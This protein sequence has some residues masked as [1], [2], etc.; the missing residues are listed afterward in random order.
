[1]ANTPQQNAESNARNIAKAQA[2]RARQ[3]GGELTAID[4]SNNAKRRSQGKMVIDFNG[5]SRES[6][7]PIAT[8]DIQTKTAPLP[9]MEMDST[10]ANQGILQS[11]QVAA[12]FQPAEG[13]FEAQTADVNDNVLSILQKQIEDLSDAENN[14]VTAED[15]FRQAQRESGIL[16]KQERSNQLQ[17]QLNEV[18]SRGQANQLAVVGQGRGIPE[19]ILGGQQ[20]QFARET[21][22]E[23][24]P[25]SAQLSAAQGDLEMA[26]RNVETLFK[27]KT[28][29]AKADYDFNVKV[30]NMVSEFATG[31]ENAKLEDIKMKE[32]RKYKETERGYTEA[33]NASQ[34]AFSNGQSELGGKINQ[35]DYKSPT[36]KADLAKLQGQLKDP[37]RELQ[38]EKLK[39]DLAPNPD[40][41]SVVKIDGTDYI[42][43][44][45]GTISLP[46]LPNM[47]GNVA[48]TEKTK[49]TIEKLDLLTRTEKGEVP[50]ALRASAG[51]IRS[52]RIPPGFIN[53]VND[54][55]SEVKTIMSGLVLD[56]LGRVKA[57]GISFG[58]LSN[59]ERQAVGDAA[60]VLVSSSIYEGEGDD[61]VPTGRFKISE[62]KVQEAFDTISKYKKIDFERRTNMSW[63]EYTN[64]PGLYAQNELAKSEDILSTHYANP[65]YS[66]LIEQA[67]ADYPEYDSA[68]ILQI[69]G[70]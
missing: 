34:M 51:A 20:A 19:A 40:I 44:K 49:D 35:L 1:M 37:L 50:L 43:Y 23:S 42:R 64:N 69:L 31:Q 57:D 10:L 60:T 58:N 29:D 27:I 12:K 24:L 39:Q 17:G 28:A 7:T 45:D 15:S 26:Q 59:G 46:I 62:G 54:W 8:T 4:K 52:K 67:V 18:V 22:I 68:E 48:S 6:K 3:N 5:S 25:I 14:R 30:I 56:E 47:E 36:F 55:R 70:L 11:E 13:S 16:Q 53:E 41:G 21:A 61:R 38:I 63:E 33:Q 2:R 66:E 32:E 9:E 65:E